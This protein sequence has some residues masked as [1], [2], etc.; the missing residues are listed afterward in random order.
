MDLDGW[1]RRSWR[2]HR[3]HRFFLRA[4]GSRLARAG[5]PGRRSG[6]AGSG[7]GDRPRAAAVA[8]DR[9]P[10]QNCR[11]APPRTVAV[12]A[13]PPHPQRWARRPGGPVARSVR[14]V[15]RA[16]AGLR[17]CPPPPGPA[18]AG[19]ASAGCRGGR[20]R[21]RPRPHPAIRGR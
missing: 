11:P 17:S 9:R 2:P 14:P 15:R 8:A 13:A 1:L 21:T 20:V 16:C 18:A 7:P 10:C 12:V 19:L 6:P 3:G 4:A 5:A